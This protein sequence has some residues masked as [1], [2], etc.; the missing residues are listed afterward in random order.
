MIKHTIYAIGLG[1]LVFSLYLFQYT[2]AFKKVT[3]TVDDRPEL[4]IIYKDYM[5]AYHKIVPII[6]DVETWAKKNNL[7]CRLSFGEYLDNPNQVEEG[8]LR[9][10]AG[11][12]IDPLV[13]EEHVQ[14]EKLKSLLP[15]NYKTGTLHPMK[16]VVAIFSGAP[17][18][19]PLKVYPKAQEFIE[20]EKLVALGS[21]IEIYEVFDAKSVQTTYLWPI[22]K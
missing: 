12:V 13:P 2:G 8:R 3:I 17:G 21:V 10:R 11:C 1:L 22:Q 15:E 5:G 20:K 9:A 6:E 14:F 18:I 16:A 4:H 7:K 19:G